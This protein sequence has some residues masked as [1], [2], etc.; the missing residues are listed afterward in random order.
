MVFQRTPRG[1]TLLLLS[2]VLIALG[3]VGSLESQA[4]LLYAGV[5]LFLFYY[6]SKLLLQLK[7]KALDGLEISREF[8]PRIDEGKALDVKLELV[9]RTFVRLSLELV[10][11]YPSFFRLRSGTNAQWSTSR[12]GASPSF[13]T[14]SSQPP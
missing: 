5:G 2:A 13:A 4:L 7:V 3:I 12:Q 10:D 11:S 8:S 1:N 6:T 9:N 14:R